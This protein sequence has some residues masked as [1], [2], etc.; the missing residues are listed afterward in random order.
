MIPGL[1]LLLG[2]ADMPWCRPHSTP[3]GL[4]CLPAQVLCPKSHS[5]ELGMEGLLKKEICLEINFSSLYHVCVPSGY[6]FL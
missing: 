4:R 6:L 2:R 3:K 1:S 5:G